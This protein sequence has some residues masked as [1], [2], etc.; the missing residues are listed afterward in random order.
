[1]SRARINFPLKGLLARN[2]CRLAR[3]P[4]RIDAKRGDHFLPADF[5]LLV[6]VSERKCKSPMWTNWSK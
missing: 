6:V 2:N 1:M 4:S 5:A 3:N